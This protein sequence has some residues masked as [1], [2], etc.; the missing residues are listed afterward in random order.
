MNAR[1]NKPNKGVS[2][3]IHWQLLW[4]AAVISSALLCNSATAVLIRNGNG[5]TAAPAD[6]PGFANVGKS[7]T[8]NASVT[9]LGNRWVLSA[10]HVTINTPVSFDPDHDGIF[11]P[12]AVDPT[13]IVQIGTADLLLFRLT[14]DPGLPSI[15]IASNSPA[16]GDTL[17]L[18]GNGLEIG[19]AHV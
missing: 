16:A 5:N 2:T 11:T 9:Y 15:D 14:T 6:D 10:S 7:S 12:F 4:I 17:V 8:G 18:V 13:T 3:N 1:G 19:R